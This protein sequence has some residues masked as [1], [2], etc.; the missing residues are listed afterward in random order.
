MPGA[1]PPLGAAGAPGRPAVGA[2]EGPQPPADDQRSPP[3]QGL[4]APTAPPVARPAPLEAMPPS[5]HWLQPLFT[6]MLATQAGV[7]IA[8]FAAGDAWGAAA[9][10]ALTILGCLALA[11]RGDDIDQ[12]Y[13]LYYSP[14]AA[15][16][17]IFDLA[18]V[19]DRVSRL[20]GEGYFGWSGDPMHNFRSVLAIACPVVELI[21]ALLCFALFK[22]GTAAGE[23]SS[24]LSLSSPAH[25]RPT[26]YLL[27]G[28]Q[29]GSTPAGSQFFKGKPRKLADLI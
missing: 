18:L 21:T 28:A 9:M 27:E 1:I 20:K 14:V 23:R 6:S 16:Q 26:E 22:T 8:R 12:G 13:A 7:A 25:S 10:L 19:A 29:Y 11:P 2:A 24:L 17:A 15:L 3:A 4:A 5:G